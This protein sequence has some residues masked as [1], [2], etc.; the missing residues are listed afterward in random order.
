M[1]AKYGWGHSVYKYNTPPCCVGYNTLPRGAVPC[2]IEGCCIL[3]GCCKGV[4]K[5]GVVYFRG[6]VLGV[7]NFWSPSGVIQGVVNI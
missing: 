7:I 1:V 2:C 6:V 5:G 3:L 4:V